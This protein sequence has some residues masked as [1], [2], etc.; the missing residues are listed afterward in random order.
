MVL[1]LVASAVGAVQQVNAYPKGDNHPIVVVPDRYVVFEPDNQPPA[2]A[3]GLGD[4]DDA[5][6]RS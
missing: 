2:T 1:V 5:S 6:L 4:Y 3:G